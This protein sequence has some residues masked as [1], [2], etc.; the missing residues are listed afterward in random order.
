MG[1]KFLNFDNTNS[2]GKSQMVIKKLSKPII[3]ENEVVTYAQLEPM[4][5]ITLNSS[6]VN[7]KIGAL[8]QFNPKRKKNGSISSP[9]MTIQQFKNK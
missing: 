5:L 2:K 1:K 9:L 7:Y 4:T 6:V 8:N 3:D